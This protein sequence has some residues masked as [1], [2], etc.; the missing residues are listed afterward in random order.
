MPVRNDYA[1]VFPNDAKIQ[2]ALLVYIREHGDTVL[3]K[4]AYQPLADV[5][6]LSPSTFNLT[7]DEYYT[8]DPK[9][10]RAWDNLVQWALRGLRKDGYLL[11][12][13]S[14]RG[15][16]SLSA[17]GVRQADAKRRRR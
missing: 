8:N 13:S 3:S 12:A 1:H 17:D 2:D 7:R 11:P 9:P 14:G 6:R 4:D 10:G 5:F 16:W 15:H